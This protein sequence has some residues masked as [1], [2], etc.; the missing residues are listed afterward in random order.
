MRQ[1]FVYLISAFLLVVGAFVTFR[2]FVRRDY[3]RRGR[4]TP[5]SGFL[6]LLIW[7][8]FMGFPYIYNPSHWPWTHDPHISPVL[9]VIGWIT[10]AV[11]AAIAFPAMAWLGLRRTMGQEANVLKRTGFYRVTRNPQIVGGALLVVGSAVL[12]PSWYGLGWVILYVAVAHLMVLTEEEH[13]RNVHGEEYT[14]YCEQV[15][16]YTGFRRG[17]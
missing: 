10:I 5:L 6:E 17:S 9:R 8:L 1:L 4:L 15:P 12:W 3:Q 2:I 13:L 7:G 14:R 11:G 16:R